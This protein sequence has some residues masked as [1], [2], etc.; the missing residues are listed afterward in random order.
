MWCDRGRIRALWWAF[1]GVPGAQLGG[2]NRWGPAAAPLQAFDRQT[3]LEANQLTSIELAMAPIKATGS[4][5]GT[6]T[7]NMTTYCTDI[8]HHNHARCRRH[9]RNRRQMDYE[10]AERIEEITQRSNVLI[11]SLQPRVQLGI[12]REQ[13]RVG[14][15]HGCSGA[16]PLRP[17]AP[18]GAGG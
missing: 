6:D 8:K 4:V 17:A 5:G 15:G 11:N 16:L 9:P 12:G 1:L 13:R 3:S 7:M 14:L 2:G 10:T 18:R